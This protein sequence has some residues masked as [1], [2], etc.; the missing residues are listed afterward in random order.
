MGGS[1]LDH[2]HGDGESL[3]HVTAAPPREEVPTDRGSANWNSWSSKAVV[4]TLAAVALMGSAGTA[5]AI[6][7]TLFPSLGAPSHSVWQ[8]PGSD[9][10]VETSTTSTSTS[11]STTSTLPPET[12]VPPETLPET[13]PETV[14]SIEDHP[15]VVG[16]AGRSGPGPSD[17]R[18]SVATSATPTTDDT[19][20]HANT[21]EPETHGGG[22]GAATTD[23][24][25]SG[26][27]K[28]GSGDNSGS[29]R[30]G[31]D[32]DPSRP[33][34]QSKPDDSTPHD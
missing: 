20:E 27:G 25:E 31:G 33:D 29:G 19:E 24:P 17:R 9:D 21:T 32:D 34:D 1:W 7:E 2:G 3:P 4:A 28:G 23:A 15:V 6:R 12:T 14:T 26:R 18:D 22:G 5:Y 30:S 13:V 10:P 11:T 16:S 8:N